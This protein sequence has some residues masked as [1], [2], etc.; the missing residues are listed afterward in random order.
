MAGE[1]KVAESG[2]LFLPKKLYSSSCI[3][4]KHSSSFQAFLLN[5]ENLGTG[6]MSWYILEMSPSGVETLIGLEGLSIIPLFSMLLW[7]IHVGEGE[8]DSQLEIPNCLNDSSKGE[9]EEESHIPSTV[10]VAF[11]RVFSGT[12]TSGQKLFVLGPK[13]NPA[14][15][16]QKVCFSH[17]F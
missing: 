7:C 16:L 5:I 9:K 8:K 15:A 1:S 4:R 3:K 6:A 17:L 13:H 2:A 12:L 10:F 14:T 11:A